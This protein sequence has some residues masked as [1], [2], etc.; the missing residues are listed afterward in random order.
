MGASDGSVWLWPSIH[1]GA[2][3]T[4]EIL[5]SLMDIGRSR[6]VPEYSFLDA[7]GVG[8]LENQRCVLCGWVV[9]GWVC[10]GCDY[11][12]DMNLLAV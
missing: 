6:I 3:Q 12:I 9:G 4:A 1:L 11:G 10:E 8:G 2:Y 5:A 7:R